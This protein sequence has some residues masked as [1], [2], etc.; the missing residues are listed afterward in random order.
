MFD[1]LHTTYREIITCIGI[2][3]YKESDIISNNNSNN[4]KNNSQKKNLPL[5][6]L[7]AYPNKESA[8]LNP[9]IYEM[10]FPD[11]NHKIPCPKFFML[12]LTNQTGQNSYLYCLKFSENFQIKN[13]DDNN[14]ENII[15]VP[16]VIFI[17]S[18]K[19]D[20]ECFKQ[21]LNII[22]YIIINDDLK[23]KKE[24]SNNDFN[25]N[26]FKKVQLLNIFYFLISLL[27][28]PPHSL[29]KLKLENEVNIDTIDSIDFYFSS[30][31][32]IPCNKNDSDINIL[33]LI[34]DQTII[35]KILFSI[36]IEK[37]I[38]FR[39]SEAYLLHII[40]PAFL[41]L[42]FPFKWSQSCIIVLP[43]EKLNF[44]EAIGPFIFGVLSDTIS[45]NDLIRE[46]PN[47]IIV[48]IDTNEIFGDSYY[49]PYYP[50]KIKENNLNNMNNNLNIEKKGFVQ[51]NNFITVDGSYLYKYEKGENNTNKKIKLN[52]EEKDNI[53]IDSQN[54]Q[55]LVD[56]TD[57]FV[58]NNERKWLR[59]NIQLVRNPEIFDLENINNNPNKNNKIYLNDNDEEE[60][61]ILPNRPFSYNI[62]NIFMVYIL[63]KLQHA[64]SV[65]MSIFTKTNLY[66]GYNDQKKYQNN[67]GRKIAE[68]IIEMKIKNK[69][70]N[71]ENCFTIEYNLQNF[72]T[73]TILKVINNSKLK[74]EKEAHE[75]LENLKNIF[76]NYRKVKNDDYTIN[77]M[78]DNYKDLVGRHSDIK[79]NVD[80]ITK[81]KKLARTRSFLL[82]ETNL[83]YN[84]NFSLEG[85]SK[86]GDG[87]FK[88]Y[89]KGGFINFILNFEK[90]LEQ[91]KFD[92]KKE[93][94]ENNIHEQILD[95]IIRD[96]SIFNQNKQIVEQLSK[97][98]K[99]NSNKKNEN[100]DNNNEIKETKEI[101]SNTETNTSNYTGRNSFLQKNGN[102]SIVMGSRTKS[103]ESEYNLLYT[104]IGLNQ[105][106]YSE[107]I[108]E[109]I[110]DFSDKKN[111]VELNNKEDDNINLR[112]QYY[113]YIAQLLEKMMESKEKSEEFINK[114]KAKKNINELNIKSLIVKL[115]RRAYNFSGKEH[116]DFPYFS[117]YIFLKN[118]D[119]DQLKLL[120]DE[121]TYIESDETELYEIYAN[122]IKEKELIIAKKEEKIKKKKKQ[123]EK[124]E[125]KVKKEKKEKNDDK[126]QL[127]SVRSSKM[128]DIFNFFENKIFDKK[129]NTNIEDSKKVKLVSQNPDFNYFIKY[130]INSDPEF[131]INII[132]NQ[133]V[134]E[135]NLIQN[136][137]K[138][139]LSILPLKK[140]ITNK[141]NKEIIIDINKRLIQ[142][143][144]L[145]E[146]IGLL[147]YFLPEKLITIKQRISFW[148][149]CFNFL[150]L[151]TLFYKKW[152]INSKDDWKYFFQNV[153]YIIGGKKYTFNDMQFILFKRP[154]FFTSNYKSNDEIK[155]LRV[156]KT[157]DFKILEKI[158]PLINNPFVIYLPI[159]DFLRP[160]IF[161]EKD[162]EY[163][164]SQRIEKYLEKY[165][166]IDEMNNLIVPELLIN[167]SQRFLYKDYKKYILFFK[168]NNIYVMLKEKKYKKNVVQNLEFKLDFDNLLE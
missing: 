162:L 168:G 87:E 12:K 137:S 66:L 158:Y 17:R 106:L 90:F 41:K 88:F 160:I 159:K 89:Q 149:N 9:F 73:K 70:R 13:N 47:I 122:T 120:N 128:H 114:I 83:N 25:I 138:E 31:C 84:Y 55:M 156:D 124:K 63:N 145:F 50:P 94:Y 35:L 79:K 112:A 32:E 136:I 1:T 53:I 37:Q 91:E 48:D 101:N 108:M 49:E 22:N 67:S 103:T 33:F 134:I 8:G 30:N 23:E 86:E 85:A 24:N 34:L 39:A 19:E 147:K 167:Y 28:A 132:N 3:G 42:I 20:L 57:V 76:Q 123:E 58:D 65:F 148:V 59:K 14:K 21:L 77:E 104:D 102:S 152:I 119:L 121:F 29:V 107:N 78:E 38:V 45:L 135:E 26:D 157:D 80:R 141:T 118:I 111:D 46:Y 40:I 11:N 116:L 7:Y 161:Y 166:Y 36:L 81:I 61:V 146:L 5:N 64:Q 126:N 98:D 117:Y 44:L 129:T 18:E 4:K 144:K 2:V 105:F 27:R 109:F 82:S 155:K 125:E 100:N 164:M 10:M 93:L 15:E 68:N 97:L 43:K 110:P 51:G 6:C 131:N 143:K 74:E 69:Q 153:L 133:I 115:Y 60:N 113:L 165:V 54:C 151:F 92:I 150:I 99:N 154:L 96:E 142:N 130:C 72:K 16:L 71:I 52:F 163:Q 56:R 75:L 95:I 62:Q 140:D 139:I 127:R